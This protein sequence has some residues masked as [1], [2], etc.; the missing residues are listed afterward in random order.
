MTFYKVGEYRGSETIPLYRLSPDHP[1]SS[2]MH[3]LLLLTP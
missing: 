1:R 2:L 3:S